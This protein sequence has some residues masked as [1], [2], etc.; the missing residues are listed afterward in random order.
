MVKEPPVTATREEL[1]KDA[2]RD[3]WEKLIAQ[4]WRIT[5]GGWTKKKAKAANP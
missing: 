2:A 3:K 1:K 4:G 5:E